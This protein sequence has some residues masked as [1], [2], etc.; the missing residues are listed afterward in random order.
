MSALAPV[1]DRSDP[2]RPGRPPFRRPTDRGERLARA[3]MAHAARA[4]CTVL[5]TI[6]TVEPWSSATFSG[7]VI[8]LSLA[9]AP[10]PALSAWLRDLPESDIPLGRDLVADIA[11]ERV[12][13]GWW[14]RVL[15]CLDAANG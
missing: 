9:A 6:A 12:D 13:G 10:G 1:A 7:S 15:L 3:L 5:L 11:V 2:I 4:G 14:L 8:A